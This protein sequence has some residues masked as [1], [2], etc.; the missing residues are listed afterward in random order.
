MKVKLLNLRG[1]LSSYSFRNQINLE[2]KWKERRNLD[3]KLV[4]KEL[5]E[6]LF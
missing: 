4:W 5:K 3:E 2:E 1:N 6:K